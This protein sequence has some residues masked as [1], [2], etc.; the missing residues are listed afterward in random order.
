MTNAFAM[1][2]VRK[3]VPRSARTW[4]RSPSKSFVWLWDDFRFSL[5]Q[6]QVFQCLPHISIMCHPHAYKVARSAQIEDPEQQKEFQNFVSFCTS[7]MLLFDLGAHFGIFSLVAA[8]FGGRAVAV[9]PSPIA[10]KMVARQ[11]HLNGWDNLVTVL[12]AAVSDTPGNVQMLSAGVFSDGYFK[13]VQDRPKSELTETLALTVD[14]LTE[15]FGM[16]T[17]MKIDVEGHEAAVLRGAEKTLREG[18]PMIFLELHNEMVTADGGNAHAPL[19]IL[20]ALNYRI[21][22]LDGTMLDRETI[23]SRALCRVTARRNVNS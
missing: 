10:T 16:P 14:Q 1:K 19:D 5:G 6:K 7:S 17:H 15:R 9:D 4:L 13:M 12:E 21:Y 8:H 18:S 3:L 11:I 2:L 23:L 22:S 20:D